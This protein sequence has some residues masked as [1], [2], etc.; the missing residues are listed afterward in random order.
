MILYY[1][2]LIKMEDFIE[3]LINSC[4][5]KSEYLNQDLIKYEIEQVLSDLPEIIVQFKK[6]LNSIENDQNLYDKLYND[7]NI[8]NQIGRLIEILFPVKNDWTGWS[9]T[10][11]FIEEL[12]FE[13]QDDFITFVFDQ[14]KN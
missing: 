8:D 2:Y 12:Y 7:D 11:K 4:C 6:E 14:I 9:Y 1:L 13:I 3:E 10:N 5:I